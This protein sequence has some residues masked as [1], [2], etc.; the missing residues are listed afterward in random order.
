MAGMI[1]WLCFVLVVYVY[2][3]YPILVWLLAR[4]RPKPPA[5]RPE[6][7]SL[8]LLIAAYNEEGCIAAKLENS[9]SLDYPSDRLQILVAADGSDD[10]TAEIV[11][12]FAARGV[13][14]SYEPERR[15]KMSAINRAMPLARGEIVVFSDA[16]NLY[17]PDT[18]REMVLPFSDP[19]VGGVSGSKMIV[20]DGDP[21]SSSEGL[22]WKYES[23]IKRQESRLGSCTSAPG[24]ILAIRRSLF[25]PVPAQ[26]INDDFATALN[27][28][29]QDRR[30]IYAP[31]ACS[32]EAVSATSRDEAARRSRISAGRFQLMA[33]SADLLP[34]RKPLLVWQI[35]SHKY[36][37]VWV[38]LAMAGAA[39]A[40]LAAVIWPARGSGWHALLRLAPPLGVA[41]LALQIIFYLTGWLGSSIKL[42]GWPGKLLY[43][44][45]YL[46][47]SN[48]AALAGFVRFLT[49]RQTPLWQRVTRRDIPQHERSH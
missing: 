2:A 38:P 26:I 44:P 19:T 10:Q 35:I 9:L 24:E 17:A 43:L 13:E 27:I 49:R 6:T 18:L 30:L 25:R 16:N 4:L 34:W 41:V 42:K 21:L 29:R 8:T 15:G 14:L 47:N 46:L 48:L 7:P 28:F 1:F 20:K 23:F 11:R 3:G 45:A 33:A 39:L 32:Y 37:R 36:L 22:Y 31:R 5:Y 12:S 40:N